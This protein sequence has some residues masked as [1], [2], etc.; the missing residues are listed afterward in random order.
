M[1]INFQYDTDKGLTVQVDGYICNGSIEY[2]V[3]DDNEN[4]VTN[5][6][7]NDKKRI[8]EHIYQESENNYEEHYLL[9]DY[10]EQFDD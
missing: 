7:N 2:H 9:N 6:T 4:K 5:L 1:Y 8:E 10:N 3:T